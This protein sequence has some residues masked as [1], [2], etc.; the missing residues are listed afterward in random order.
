MPFVFLDQHGVGV[1]QRK[2]S[3]RA[4]YEKSF[5]APGHLGLV[6]MDVDDVVQ[7]M[8]PVVAITAMAFVASKL[9]NGWRS[10]REMSHRRRTRAAGGDRQASEGSFPG[11]AD[12][13]DSLGAGGGSRDTSDAAEEAS[14]GVLDDPSDAPA[15]SGG[16][17]PPQVRL[18]GLS[19]ESEGRAAKGDGVLSPFGR[20]DGQGLPRARL[21]T[22]GGV[23]FS[24]PV[25]GRRN[26]T[27]GPSDAKSES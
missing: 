5:S 17:D 9:W 4:Y 6:L 10:R 24:T 23:P 26:L 21:R 11:E 13:G 14:G 2:H 19:A 1:P 20:E 22:S 3:A 7:V 12:V 16:E 25:L 8:A 15:A 27:S 18:V